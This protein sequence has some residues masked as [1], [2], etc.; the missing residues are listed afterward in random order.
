M[1]HMNGKIDRGPLPT[2]LNDFSCNAMT[3]QIWEKMCSVIKN[4]H[5]NCPFILRY[6][7]NCNVEAP[8]GWWR[9]LVFR[10]VHVQCALYIPMKKNHISH[11][12][13]HYVHILQYIINEFAVCDNFFTSLLPSRHHSS[14]EIAQRKCVHQFMLMV[15]YD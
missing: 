8:Q 6:N 13:I 3:Q 7:G 14:N 1:T 9:R 12:S 10:L 2:F 4:D 11:Q 5:F 15:L